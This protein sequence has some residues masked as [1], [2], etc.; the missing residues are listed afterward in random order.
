[1]DGLIISPLRGLIDL[2]F[3][4]CYNLYIPSGLRNMAI[5]KPRRGVMFIEK[6]LT[7]HKQTPKG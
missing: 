1:M 7:Q 3:V 2:W 6:R 4:L 5:F